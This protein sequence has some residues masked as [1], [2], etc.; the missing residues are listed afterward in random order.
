MNKQELKSLLE[1]IYH[2]LSEN[3]DGVPPQLIPPDSRPT[4]PG[5]YVPGYGFVPLP[6]TDD[7]IV[8]QDE[9]DFGLEFTQEQLEE[10]LRQAREAQRRLEKERQRLEDMRLGRP[11]RPEGDGGTLG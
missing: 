7:E 3:E 11:M 2:L 5:Y 8:D 10:M 9:G 4:S 1:N 6:P